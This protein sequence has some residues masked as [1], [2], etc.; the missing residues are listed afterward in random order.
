MNPFLIVAA[1]LT[2][3]IGVAHSWL[4]ERYLLRRLFRRS[5]LPH[6]FGSD[7]FT[8]RTLR[9]AWHLTTVAWWGLG[10][11]L[12]VVMVPRPIGGAPHRMLEVVALTFLATAVATL[13]GSRGRHL[14]WLVFLLI[15]ITAWLGTQ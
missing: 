4:G 1:V 11:L 10:A 13:V 6:L 8:K 3:G 5:N 12:L 2:F 14:A 15:A 9:L 7:V